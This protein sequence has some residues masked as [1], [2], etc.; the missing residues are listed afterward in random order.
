MKKSLPKISDLIVSRAG[1]TCCRG[2]GPLVETIR[3]APISLSQEK[4]SYSNICVDKTHCCSKYQRVSG[5]ACKIKNDGY[6]ID[7]NLDLAS[8]VTFVVTVEIQTWFGA[9][10]CTNS[11]PTPVWALQLSTPLIVRKRTT[12]AKPVGGGIGGG[13]GCGCGRVAEVVVV[14][15]VVEPPGKYFLQKSTHLNLRQPKTHF[16][17]STVLVFHHTYESHRL[18]RM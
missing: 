15:V 13:C 16:G 6:G 17:S 12:S 5:R 4:K 9:L 14:V 10:L 18:K 7:T 2:A 8:S 3:L 1:P 11:V